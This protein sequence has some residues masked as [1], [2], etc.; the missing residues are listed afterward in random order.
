MA[1]EALYLGLDLSTQ[2]LKAIAVNPALQPV[3]E[4]NVNFDADLSHHGIHKGVIA[5]AGTDEVFAPVAMYLEALELV[6]GRLKEN[7]LDLG[8][9]KGISGAGMQ[10]GTV[11]WSAK[12]EQLLAELD[13]EKT[14]AEQLAPAAFTHEFAPNWQDASTEEECGAFNIALGGPETLA[15]VTGSRAHHR[16][17]GPQILKFRKHHPEAYAATARISLISSFLASLFLGH[18]TTIEASDAC[19]MNLLNILT[20]TWHP[21]LLSLTAGT[22]AAIPSLTAKLGPVSLDPSAPLGSISPYFTHR[23]GLNP[24]CTIHPFTGDNPATLLALP[25]AQSSAL[26]SLGTSTT[27]L[28]STPHYVPH[29]DYHL[30]LHPTVPDAYMFMLCYK[31]GAL[32]REAVRDAIN[33]KTGTEA[34]GEDV[35]AAFQRAMDAEKPLGRAEG[36]NVSRL[37]LFFPRPEIVPQAPA[38]TWRVLYDESTGGM[39]DVPL[40]GCPEW[41]VPEADARAILESQFLSMRLRARAMMTPQTD[42]ADPA[43]KLPDQ[44]GRVYLVGGGARSDAIVGVA[45]DVLGGVEGVYRLE[46]GGNACALGGAY[47]AAWG[48]EGG[49]EGFEEWLKGRWEEHKFAAKVGKGYDAERWPVYGDVLRGFEGLEA[50]AVGFGDVNH[51][52]R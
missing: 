43:K 40:E 5:P 28:M 27:F 11:F 16:F 33:A 37:G 19:G 34:E 9:V 10:H 47:R 29:P 4:A 45:G 22:P 17:S 18:I 50:K 8:R 21:A 25:L 32:A 14:L 23:F 36:S 15:R 48:E 41:S 12:A 30:F 51:A 1:S 24:A 52:A 7:G 26:I 42:P 31:N 35:W 49:G 3:C 20:R 2:G 46:V 44:P 38:G 6:L 13:P 39:T